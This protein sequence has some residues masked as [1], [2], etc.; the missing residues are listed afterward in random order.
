METC[1]MCD[2]VGCSW[3][4]DGVVPDTM[5]FVPPGDLKTKPPKQKK[6]APKMVARGDYELIAF[7]RRVPG[8]HLVRS[9][10][11]YRSAFTWCGLT[12]RVTPIGDDTVPRCK[13]CERALAEDLLTQKETTAS[14]RAE[15]H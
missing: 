11:E 2:G 15:K 3:C 9:T 13:E 10:N 6:N 1:A 7:L 12:G 8:F 14:R 4:D 5:L